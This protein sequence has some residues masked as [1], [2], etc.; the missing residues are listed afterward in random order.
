[1]LRREDELRLS[2]QTQSKY[3]AAPDDYC[4]KERITLAVQRKVCREFGF[5]HDMEEGLDLLRSAT[6]L[7]P[8]DQEVRDSAHW[9]KFNIVARCPIKVGELVPDVSLFRQDGQQTSVHQLL[10]Q[11]G[12][13]T[14]LVAGSHT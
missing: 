4:S 7:F 14:V 13:P 11:S 9:L 5:T 10:D 1:M 3:S 12:V 2:D 8:N 6:A